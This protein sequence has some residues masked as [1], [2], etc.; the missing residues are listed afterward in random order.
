[1][2]CLSKSNFM[3]LVSQNHLLAHPY[4]LKG[5]IG[6]TKISIFLPVSLIFHMMSTGVKGKARCKYRA[7]CVVKWFLR[8]NT[9][10]GLT[11]SY[12]ADNSKSSIYWFVLFMIGFVLTLMGISSTIIEYYNYNSLTKISYEYPREL[13]LPAVAICNSNRIHCYNL[14]DY[15]KAIPEVCRNLI[16][17][18]WA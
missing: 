10:G 9:M 8:T 12:H 5:G 17:P 3:T 1:M 6:S 16:H 18:F 15:I 14:Y 2:L 7:L 4:L 11:S 13:T